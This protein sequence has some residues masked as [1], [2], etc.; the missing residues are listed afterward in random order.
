VRVAFNLDDP[1]RAEELLEGLIARNRRQMRRGGIPPLYQ[2]GIKYRE[3]QPGKE[4]WLTAKEG[5]EKGILDCEDLTGYRI[6]ELRETGENKARPRIVK[7]GPTTYHAIVQR[8]DG[9]M[10]DPTK[11]LKRMEATGML[12]AEL[13]TTPA[14]V[15]PGA[16]PKTHLRFKWGFRKTP[17]GWTGYVAVPLHLKKELLS[18]EPAMI[19]CG[20]IHG[21]GRGRTK[22]EAADGAIKDNLRRQAQFM[23]VQFRK[24]REGHQEILDRLPPG[25]RRHVENKM[26]EQ[27]LGF[28][29]GLTSLL[30]G[31]SSLI[32]G[33]APTTP[34][35]P[36]APTMPTI[37]G[38]PSLPGVFSMI[39]GL[40]S[41]IPGAAP[42]IPGMP[43]TPGLPGLPF[44]PPQATALLQSLLPMTSALKTVTAPLKKAAKSLKSKA[45][46]FFKKLKFWGVDD[47][48][49][50]L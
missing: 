33:M 3:E 7:T 34:T 38:M 12:G 35:A 49:E 18:G 1:Y 27:T 25:V 48:I 32:P 24:L 4:D 44:V 16:R 28:F 29:P 21:K 15:P 23:K 42:T 43:A 8:G 11:V 10:E 31:L 14:A 46:K 36:A 47:F 30:P 41:M 5:L 37:P 26:R 2:S 13:K 19:Q 50:V 39:P 45:K 17:G 20:W 6:A 9:S 40:S 22:A